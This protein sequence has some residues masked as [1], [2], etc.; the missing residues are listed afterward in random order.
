MKGLY[1]NK[2][3]ALVFTIVIF[4]TSCGNSWIRDEYKQDLVNAAVVFSGEANRAYIENDVEDFCNEIHTELDELLNFE[5]YSVFDVDYLLFGL[6]EG[7]RLS[8]A[9][10]QEAHSFYW[11]FDDYCR[12]RPRVWDFSDTWGRTLSGSVKELESLF[13]RYN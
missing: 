11:A 13:Q 2:R 3:I 1:I 10:P 7:A 5:Y 4:I 12:F 6:Y 8:G 9:T